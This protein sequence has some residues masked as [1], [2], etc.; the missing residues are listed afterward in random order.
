MI[1]RTTKFFL[2]FALLLIPCASLKA[3]GTQT[4]ENIYVPK[5]EIVSGNFYAAGNSIVIDGDI[6]GDLFAIAQSITVNGQVAGDIIAA[7]QDIVING[8]IDGNVRVAGSSITINGAVARNVNAFGSNIILGP[9]SA[10]G[11]DAYVAGSTLFVRGTIDGG[12]DGHAGQ[13][14]ITGKIGKDLNLK[15]AGTAAN[16]LT[17]SSEAIINGDVN[18]TSDTAAEI[19]TTAS[20]AG[21]VQQKAPEIKT[22]NLFWPWVWGRLFAI[23]AAI[24]VGLVMTTLCKKCLSNIIGLIEEKKARAL[25]PGLLIFFVVPP[26]AL[27]LMFTVIGIPLA[28]ILGVLWLLAVYIA[29]I[30]TAVLLGNLLIKKVLKKGELSLTWSLVPGVIICWLLFSIPFAGWVLGL[31][32]TWLGLGGLWFYATNQSRNI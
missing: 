18:Y 14:V 1:R 6:S 30:F 2:F 4:G 19:S 23:F 8:K 13:A 11:W 7:S 27:V 10:I 17:I 26:A 24:A 21:N 31:I 16:K 12:L 15:L 3:A 28:L 5:E 29:K 20:I 9:D 22:K 32:A 25:I